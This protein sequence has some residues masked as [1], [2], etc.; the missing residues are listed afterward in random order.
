MQLYGI[1]DSETSAFS[2]SLESLSWP[3]LPSYSQLNLLLILV[4][5]CLTHSDVQWHFLMTMMREYMLLYFP[6]YMHLHSSWLLAFFHPPKRNIKVF[7]STIERVSSAKCEFSAFGWLVCVTKPVPVGFI[8][9]RIHFLPMAHFQ[10][11]AL[12]LYWLSHLLTD[13]LH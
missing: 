1:Y 13:D 7:W 12:E 8:A 6:K 4:T 9:S 3:P 2:I 10:C 11:L 5:Q